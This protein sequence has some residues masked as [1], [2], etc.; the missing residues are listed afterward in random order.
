[1]YINVYIS[2]VLRYFPPPSTCWST[3]PVC[4]YVLYRNVVCMYSELTL[5]PIPYLLFLC[6]DGWW[7]F[8]VMC[9]TS[10]PAHARVERCAAVRRWMNRCILLGSSCQLFGPPLIP[11]DRVNSPLI[12]RYG[13]VPLFCLPYLRLAHM[14]YTDRANQKRFAFVPHVFAAVMNS[15]VSER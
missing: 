12:T 1:M 7:G 8:P 2:L 4:M 5:T 11:T 3:V 15:R 6:S 13:P 14:H 9:L 10:P